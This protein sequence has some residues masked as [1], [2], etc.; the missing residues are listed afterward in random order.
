MTK[1]KPK[2][3][4]NRNQDCSAS[5]E[6]STPT[7]ASPGYPNTLEKQ[8]SDV[9]SH[10]MMLV[11]DF[12]K[13]INNSLKEIQENIA[14]QVEILKE[15]TQKSLKE[16][17]ENTNKQVMELNKAIQ[18]LK[19]EVEKKNKENPKGDNSGDRK[20]RNEIRSHRCEQHQENTRNGRENLRCRRFHTKHGQDNQRKCKM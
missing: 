3:L 19:M 16:L 18:D 14:K 12:K 5:S 9:K 7:T 10:L 20:P 4:T 15:E 1:G 2:N 17:Q 8:D 13:D 6:P 11:E